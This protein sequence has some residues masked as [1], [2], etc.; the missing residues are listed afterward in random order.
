MSHELPVS[1]LGPAGFQGCIAPS[2]ER[3]HKESVTESIKESHFFPCSPYL[4]TDRHKVPGGLIGQTRFV[5]NILFSIF[6]LILK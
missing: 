6:A 4:L 2:T 5:E 3:I 1:V